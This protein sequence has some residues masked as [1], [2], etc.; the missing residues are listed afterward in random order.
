MSRARFVCP[1]S[2]INIFLCVQFDSLLYEVSKSSSAFLA[3]SLK[4]RIQKG[5]WDKL[6]PRVHDVE[7]QASTLGADERLKEPEREPE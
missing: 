2:T 3:T 4:I 5:S 1:P 7:S 6:L